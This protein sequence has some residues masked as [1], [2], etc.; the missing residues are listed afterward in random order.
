MNE[1]CPLRI[2]RID[3]YVLRCVLLSAIMSR[4]CDERRKIP[5][6]LGEGRKYHP[7]FVDLGESENAKWLA[8]TARKPLVQ[9]L[10]GI[11]RI[12]DVTRHGRQRGPVVCRNWL[13]TP[14]AGEHGTY[15]LL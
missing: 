7:P 3:Y 14:N 5:A 1:L 12:R 4:R 10:A 8:M 11:A 13:A 2:R 6:V 15:Y 9:V